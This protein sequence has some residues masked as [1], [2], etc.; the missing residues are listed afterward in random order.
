LGDSF[1]IGQPNEAYSEFQI[2]L[3]KS[4]SPYTVVVMNVVNGH[5]GYLPPQ[6][7]YDKNIYSV[8]QTPFA[9]GS[10]EILIEQAKK[11]ARQLIER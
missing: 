11:I 2:N 9:S 6:D 10:L 8:W 5:I 1:F 3:R 4:L 7:L